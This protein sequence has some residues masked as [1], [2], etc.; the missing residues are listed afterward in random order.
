MDSIEYSYRY[1]AMRGSLDPDIAVML[2]S[3]HRDRDSA[4]SALQ[5]PMIEDVPRPKP[6]KHFGEEFALTGQRAAG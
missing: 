4:V 3:S 5:R 6:L 2:I 1:R